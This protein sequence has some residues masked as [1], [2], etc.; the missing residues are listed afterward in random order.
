M[1]T[2]YRAVV[3][4]VLEP[5]I[6]LYHPARSCEYERTQSAES[7][8][9]C[10]T[11]HNTQITVSQRCRVLVLSSVRV[12]Y[13]RSLMWIPRFPAGSGFPDRLYL[14]SYLHSSCIL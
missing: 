7:L 10:V 11:Q 14:R 13:S 8:R 1:G 5:H 3:G 12:P 6:E 4:R 9:D 2:L